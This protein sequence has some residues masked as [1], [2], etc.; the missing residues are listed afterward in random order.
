VPIEGPESV[1]LSA[2][3]RELVKRIAERDGISEDEAATR[4]AKAALERR[5]RKRTRYGP[6]KVFEMKRR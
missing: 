3:E 5:V 2:K 6:A 4:L 1:P